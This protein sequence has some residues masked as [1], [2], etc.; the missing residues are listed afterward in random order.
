MRVVDR[1]FHHARRKRSPRPIRF[2]RTLGQC[3]S[4]KALDQR[5]QTELANPEQARRDHGVENLARCE[6]QTS[7]QQTQIEIGAV[8]NDFLFLERLAQRCKIDI[9]Q[10]IDQHILVRNADLK[11]TKFLVVTMETVCFRIERYALDR[12]DA[13]EQLG[14][15][16]RARDRTFRERR[17]TN[18]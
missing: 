9:R 17:M 18:V 8:Q 1:V 14:Q 4:E 11:Q 13:F 10:R 12:F 2:L 3:H 16:R 15:S 7:A 5:G 6:I